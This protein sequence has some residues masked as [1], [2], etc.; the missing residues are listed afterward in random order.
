[1]NVKQPSLVQYVTQ[2]GEDTD[3]TEYEIRDGED[4]PIVDKHGEVLPEGRTFVM[5]DGDHYPL[6]SYLSEHE[7]YADDESDTPAVAS[8]AAPG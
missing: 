3:T 5:K 1:M 4:T 8:A 6:S 7:S 2:A